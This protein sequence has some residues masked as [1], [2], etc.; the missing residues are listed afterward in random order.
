[1]ASRWSPLVLSLT[2]LI[3]AGFMLQVMLGAMIQILPV[4]AGANMA[5][6]VWVARVVHAMTALG[7]LF[8]AAAFLGFSASLFMLA[9]SFL[10]A[11]VV[12]FIGSAA[13]A[14]YGVPS[15]SPA[16]RGV[17]LAL[18]GLSVTVSLG[19]ILVVSVVGLL[20]LP[21]TLLANVHL[22][23]GFVAWGS[24][25]LAAV[26]FVVV[27]MFQLTPAYPDW[28]G[29]WYAISALVVVMLWTMAEF[30]A[31]DVGSAGF[32]AVVVV[33]SAMFAG[34]TLDIQR[35]TKRARLD[36]T[37]RYWRFSML[38]ALAACAIWL[39]AATIPA[40]GDWSEWPL[41]FGVILLFGG[42]MSVISGMLYKIVPFLVWLHL[43][44]QGQGRV[45]A[46]NMKKIIGEGEMNGQMRAH[47]ASCTLLLLAVC[48][49]NGFDYPAGI[50]VIVANAW[51]L[52]NL[53]IAMSVYRNHQLRI[54]SVID[55]QV[56]P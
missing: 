13:R 17:K 14:L 51:L 18:V 39:A 16:I 44:Q 31:W 35:R 6:P 46:P 20:D 11:G 54:A 33:A 2:H 28:F 41:L 43:Q 36:A 9:A 56:A 1:M 5:R 37:Q 48:W 34:V 38:S 29:R 12:F 32:G 50:A 19:V 23:W 53:L 27:P 42:F 4:V 8:L 49:P 3:T 7:A 15:T 22:G 10:F 26:A 24:I 47:F 52:R 55:G 45:M 25:L 30:L 21:V 40:V